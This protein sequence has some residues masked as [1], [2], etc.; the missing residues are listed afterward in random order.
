MYNLFFSISLLIYFFLIFENIGKFINFFLINKIYDYKYN[1]I[2]GFSLF[3]ILTNIFYF[4]FNFR[5]T[6]INQFFLL[7]LIFINIF[8]FKKKLYPKNYLF[9]FFIIIFISTPFLLLNYFYG[10]QFFVFRGN[11]YDSFAY[12]FTALNF[13]KLPINYYVNSIDFNFPIKN[14]KST[15][16]SHGLTNIFSRPA[17]HLFLSTIYNF[18][19]LTIF[20]FNLIFKIIS[21]ILI[22]FS[23]QKIF[24]K[25]LI[26]QN[27]IIFYSISFVFS[28]WTIY[29]FEI[30]AFSQILSFGIFNYCLFH[31]EEF[32]DDL[33]KQ[34]KNHIFLDLI[35]LICLLYVYIEI[36]LIFCFVV[37]I[38]LILD[39]KYLLL[40][41]KKHKQRILLVLCI[42]SLSILIQPHL[43]KFAFNQVINGTISDLNW[44]G[45][46]GS[47][48]LGNDYDLHSNKSLIFSVKSLWAE[49]KIL[50]LLSY[51]H[52]FLI[53]IKNH[54]YLNILPSAFGFYFLTAA[55]NQYPLIN[56]LLLIFVNILFMYVIFI[57][58]KK[59]FFTENNLILKSIF[60]SFTIILVLLCFNLQF[61]S[62]I[63]FYFFFSFFNFYIFFIHSSIPA[64]LK[65]ILL[66]SLL[67]FPFYKYSTFNDGIGRFDNFPSILD[68]EYKKNSKFNLSNQS[69]NYCNKSF[70]I[71]N[72]YNYINIDF[73]NDS[74]SIY[75]SKD[76]DL[77]EDHQ[78]ISYKKNNTKLE[79]INVTY[80]TSKIFSNFNKNK[81]FPAIYYFNNSNM[82]DLLR[83]LE[84]I[85][86]DCFII[87]KNK[88]F[89]L[90]TLDN[91][92]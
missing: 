65:N 37:I 36:F 4:N 52:D 86:P 14:I 72:D 34:N 10:E 87:F 38:N 15:V 51:I 1:I 6:L 77:L 53:Q 9:L 11:H 78:F 31:I 12:T 91:L 28:F 92:K 74:L 49:K 57:S 32:K 17:A 18:K 3:V 84:I 41:F 24:E 73:V 46:F 68:Q 2:I 33:I 5:V 88:N 43:I 21:V 56:M 54:Y 82:S 39:Y 42:F 71:F 60:I 47:F 89:N 19:I 27:L 40:L 75:L 35:I 69:Y 64:K 13:E 7:S 44:W 66:L 63:K 83:E 79:A 20:D 45:Y 81:E 85:N 50:A 67:I 59:L 29:I 8:F 90:I 62:A 26:K 23:C 61:W 55:F 58:L 25:L 16:F 80:V 22:F 76:F 30:D 48:I 70:Y